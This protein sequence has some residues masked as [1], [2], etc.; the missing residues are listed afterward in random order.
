M[1]IPANEL[2]TFACIQT[3]KTSSK[4]YSIM[5]VNQFIFVSC[6]SISPYYSGLRK[7]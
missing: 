4:I 3:N 1:I 2:K 7:D 6:F 5:R